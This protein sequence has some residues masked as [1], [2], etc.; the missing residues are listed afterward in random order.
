MS[1]MRQLKPRSLGR[2]EKAWRIHGTP[3]LALHL[4]ILGRLVDRC[5]VRRLAEFGLNVAQWRAVALLSLSGKSTF[6]ELADYAWLDRG[7]LSRA[8]RRLEANGVVRRT[9][10]PADKRSSFLALT[11]RGR[12]IYSGFSLEWRRFEHE[13]D[14]L[15]SATQLRALNASLELLAIQCLN[16]LSSET[17]GRSVSVAAGLPRAARNSRGNSLAD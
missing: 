12:R 2:L 7:D 9:P 4:A 8:L 14:R 10:N 6:R 15:F 3:N 11:A 13:F 5:M 1:L 16:H 17:P